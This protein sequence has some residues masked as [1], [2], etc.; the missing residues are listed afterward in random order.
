[1]LGLLSF[2]LICPTVLLLQARI[3][4]EKRK[5]TGVQKLSRSRARRA[6]KRQNAAIVEVG[7]PT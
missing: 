4:W 7:F 1:V 6:R 5:T 2:A 3:A